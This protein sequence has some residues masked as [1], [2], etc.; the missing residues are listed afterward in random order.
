MEV[1]ESKKEFGESEVVLIHNT[2]AAL[3]SLGQLFPSTE[4]KKSPFS[5]PTSQSPL[6]LLLLLL[7]QYS[8]SPHLARVLHFDL[9]VL[10]GSHF[11][12]DFLHHIPDIVYFYVIIQVPLGGVYHH[13]LIPVCRA[14]EYA[15]WFG[16]VWAGEERG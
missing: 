11:P 15:E 9:V 10:K 12:G 3:S 16:E 4:L 7:L 6:S 8:P 2:C 5:F 1:R 13:S 14:W